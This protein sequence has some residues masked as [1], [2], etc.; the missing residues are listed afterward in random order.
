MNTSI[1]TTTEHKIGAVTYYVISAPQQE[2]GGNAGQE[3][4][5]ADSERYAGTLCKLPLF[6]LKT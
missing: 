6:R 4:G 3:S 1:H 5:K 2:R